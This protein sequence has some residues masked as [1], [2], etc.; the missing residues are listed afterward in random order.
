MFS[1]FFR[2]D[3][4]DRVKK[5]M[6]DLTKMYNLYEVKHRRQ[7]SLIPPFD[8]ADIDAY[9]LQNSAIEIILITIAIISY[10][11]TGIIVSLFC[12]KSPK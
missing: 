4:P 1:Q 9:F 8:K 5:Y 3:F 7:Y 11:S 10:F 12:N 2:V 6:K